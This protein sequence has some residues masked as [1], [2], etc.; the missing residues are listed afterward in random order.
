VEES[1]I[2]RKGRTLLRKEHGAPVSKNN[3]E[4]QQA[5]IGKSNTEQKGIAQGTR[6]DGKRNLP[7]DRKGRRY[8]MKGSKRIS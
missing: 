3:T 6:Q 8:V 1:P 4:N 2:G 5:K 7:R